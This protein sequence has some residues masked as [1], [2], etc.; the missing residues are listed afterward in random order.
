MK[1]EEKVQEIEQKLAA[2]IKFSEEKKID[3]SSEIEK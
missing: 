3:L 2:L 1:F